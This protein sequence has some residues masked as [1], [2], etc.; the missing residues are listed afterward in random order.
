MS[1]IFMICATVFR[2]LCPWQS[3]RLFRRLSSCT[4]TDKIPLE[5]YKRAFN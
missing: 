4:A 1:P 5:C 3:L 2:D